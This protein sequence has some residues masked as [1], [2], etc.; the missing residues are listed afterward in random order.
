MQ[1]RVVLMQQYMN[2]NK[3]YQQLWRLNTNVY[4]YWLFYKGC[5]GKWMHIS[6]RVIKEV[7]S[8]D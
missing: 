5:E 2:Y 1:V 4:Q 3:P 7:N 8:N 6:F